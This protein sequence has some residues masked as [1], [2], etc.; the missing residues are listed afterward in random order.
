MKELNLILDRSGSM[1][2]NGKDSICLSIIQSLHVIREID[3][4]FSSLIINKFKFGNSKTDFEELKLKCNL[5]QTIILTDGYFFFDNFKGEIKEFLK[6]NKKNLY[7]ILC[8]AD[9]LDLSN[10]KKDFPLINS[11]RPEDLIYILSSLDLISEE[12]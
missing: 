11:Y 7:F 6:E 8:G 10:Y 12:K 9:S 4:K 2:M 1:E 3:S 5:K